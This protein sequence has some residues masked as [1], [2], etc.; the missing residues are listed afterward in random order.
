MYGRIVSES[1]SCFNGCLS[2]SFLAV[3]NLLANISA[4]G[5][6]IEDAFEL[7]IKAMNYAEKDE[8]YQLADRE[9]KLLTAKNEDDKQPLKQLLDSL[10][11]S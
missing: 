4:D 9:V 7:Y 1:N 2:S 8:F 3:N 11:I 5:M 10:S 6:S